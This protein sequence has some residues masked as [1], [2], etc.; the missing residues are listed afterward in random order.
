MAETTQQVVISPHDKNIILAES[1]MS[2]A[3]ITYDQGGSWRNINLLRGVYSFAFD[4]VDPN[5]IYA[6]TNMLF[7]S[8]DQ[9]HTWHIL[10]PNPDTITKMMWVTDDGEC[11]YT[12]N[13]PHFTSSWANVSAIWHRSKHT[14][15]DY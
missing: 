2:G 13:D 8:Q 14:H 11:H 3:Y 9:G 5:V 4:P 6:G 1:D 7:Q 10:A 15:N 12:S